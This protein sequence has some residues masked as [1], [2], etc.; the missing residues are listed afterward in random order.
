MFRG[1]L[2]NLYRFLYGESLRCNCYPCEDWL[3][4]ALLLLLQNAPYGV[5]IA[6]D[7]IERV[8]KRQKCDIYAINLKL[9][10]ERASQK[11]ILK[12][13]EV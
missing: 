1:F 5:D 10:N 13:D 8:L 12:G 6:I 7:S 3:N 4:D 2:E 9:L 11:H